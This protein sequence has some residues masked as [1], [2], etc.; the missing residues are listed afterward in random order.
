MKRPTGRRQTTSGQKAMQV[1]KGNASAKLL[2]L[3]FIPESALFQNGDDYST[4]RY[5]LNAT[6]CVMERLL[7]FLILSSLLPSSRHRCFIIKKEQLANS[8]RHEDHVVVAGFDAP[9]DCEDRGTAWR[10]YWIRWHS[11]SHC[12]AGDS[13]NSRGA[14]VDISNNSDSISSR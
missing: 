6:S 10:W 1:R 5:Y 7:V 3:S 4:V 12:A 9:A 8:W 13:C 14:K 2:T 11:R